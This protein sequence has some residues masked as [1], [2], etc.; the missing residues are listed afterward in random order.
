MKKKECFQLTLEGAITVTIGYLDVIDEVA[1]L[2]M[3]AD[4]I[5][6][7]IT[8]NSKW[9][10]SNCSTICIQ[11]NICI[12]C[13]VPLNQEITVCSKKVRAT[14]LDGSW[15]AK[16]QLVWRSGGK[17]PKSFQWTFFDTHA[18]EVSELIDPSNKTFLFFNL[19]PH[20]CTWI[21]IRAFMHRKCCCPDQPLLPHNVRLSIEPCLTTHLHRKQDS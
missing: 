19:T 17:L 7:E 15:A 5:A 3:N 1:W 16:E 18:T 8:G 10:Y 13:S 12:S 11:S 2:C 21:Q 20:I 6:D 14:E 4:P 9:M